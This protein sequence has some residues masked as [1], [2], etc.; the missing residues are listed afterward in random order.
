MNLRELD[1]AIARELGWAR[2]TDQFRQGH[3]IA[4][5]R[6]P[7]G[8]KFR[9]DNMGYGPPAYSTYGEAMLELIEEMGKRGFG[10]AVSHTPTACLVR[11]CSLKDPFDKVVN[12]LEK[13][14]PEAVSR[15]CLAALTS[16]R[17]EG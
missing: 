15:A 1:E 5:W 9:A 10:V 4:G 17:G 7:D 6:S 2:S 12:S 8:S 16:E 13:T 3:E 11:V 14:A